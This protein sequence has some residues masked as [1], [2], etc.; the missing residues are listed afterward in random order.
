MWNETINTRTKKDCSCL[1]LKLSDALLV[2][3]EMNGRGAKRRCLASR[4]MERFTFLWDC[5][6][7]VARTVL[8]TKPKTCST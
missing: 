8:L 4:S 2:E 5:F 1:I 3:I 6:K 7:V